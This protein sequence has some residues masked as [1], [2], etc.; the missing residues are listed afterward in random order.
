[1]DHK[2]N[3]ACLL[4]ICFLLSSNRLLHVSDS[5]LRVQRLSSAKIQNY[6]SFNKG[7]LC[8]GKLCFNHLDVRAGD[9]VTLDSMRAWQWCSSL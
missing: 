2:D 4:R 8:L 6:F 7:A 1:M 3:A 5:T 9:I